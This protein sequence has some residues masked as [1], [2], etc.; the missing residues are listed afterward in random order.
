MKVALCFIIS[1]DHILNKEHIWR[2]WIEPNADLINVYFHYK[3]YNKIQ[4]AWIKEHAIPVSYIAYTTYYHVVPAY[5]NILSYAFNHDTGNQWFCMLTD[6]CVPIISPQHFRNLFMQYYKDSIFRW[7][8]AWWNVHLNGRANLRHLTEEFHLGHDPWF[9][10]KREDVFRCVRF[11]LSRNAMYKRVCE[12]GLANESVFA[13]MLHGLKQL[14]YVKNE[15]S[16]MTNWEKMSSPTS[17]YIFKTG[18]EEDIQFINTFLD[19]NKYTMFLRKVDPAFPDE[20]L[21]HFI[22]R[23]APPVAW[24]AVFAYY[25]VSCDVFTCAFLMRTQVL[26]FLFGLVVYFY[27]RSV[28]GFGSGSGGIFAT[29]CSIPSGPSVLLYQSS[30]PSFSTCNA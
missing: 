19:V 11:A 2:E 6:S 12:G 3:D 24:V 17:P 4:S 28:F 5:I 10:L 27:F 9:V 18:T 14:E 1:Y 29:S 26:L 30:N 7:K 15:V 8:K 16:H 23:P 22:R 13:I 20:I 25:V 21:T